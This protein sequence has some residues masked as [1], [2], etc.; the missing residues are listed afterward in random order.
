MIINKLAALCK[1]NGGFLI[2]D[3]TTRDNIALGDP[4]QWIGVNGGMYLLQNMPYLE[5]AN[6]ATLLGYDSEKFKKAEVIHDKDGFWSVD[7]GDTAEDEK[8]ATLSSI[9]CER[10]KYK[11]GFLLVDDRIEFINLGSLAPF[12]DIEE[13]MKICARQDEK[14]QIYFVIKN[15]LI[16]VG[17]IWPIVMSGDHVATELE[18]M[19]RMARAAYRDREA[20]K[21]KIVNDA[22]K[23]A[24]KDRREQK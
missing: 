22:K 17:A 3:Q 1:K 13:Y 5:K 20:K 12:A 8:V 11:M 10:E 2:K 9:V 7:I 19:A 16:T 6:F 24:A 4:C 23:E 14:G 15:G 18:A 21:A